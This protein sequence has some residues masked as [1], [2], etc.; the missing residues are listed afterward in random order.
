[1]KPSV[2]KFDENLIQQGIDLARECNKLAY[3]PY[4]G[5]HVSAVLYIAAHREF[6]QGVNVENMSFGAT[7]C[8]ERS[9]L[10]AAVSKYGQIAPDFLIIY[11]RARTLTPPCGIC[12]QFIAEFCG[13]DFPIILVNDKDE[14]RDMT[15]SELFPMPFEEFRTGSVLDQKSSKSPV[16]L[17]D[18]TADIIEEVAALKVKK[19][20]M[21][22]VNDVKFF[23]SQSA[24]DQYLRPLAIYHDDTLV[25]FCTYGTDDEDG[26]VWIQ[27][28][29]IH[30]AYQGRGYSIR[31]LT[32]LI[33][34]IRK[35]C[36]PFAVFA[37]IREKNTV[38]QRI[39]R[40]LGFS[41]SGEKDDDAD[42][43]MLPLGH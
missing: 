18:V 40:K 1:M 24:V 19:E 4:S 25:G 16:I 3:A 11:T 35:E 17:K 42:L 33:E 36:N 20:Q 29:M 32:A 21:G 22:L 6:I 12:R 37:G 14:R 39:F 30:A 28:L 8:A 41:P 9:A 31:A 15:F 2:K 7:I 38:A 13:G 43:W 10:C 5:F 34:I 26:K 23:L 27:G